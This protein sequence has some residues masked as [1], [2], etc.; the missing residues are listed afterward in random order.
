MKLLEWMCMKMDHKIHIYFYLETFWNHLVVFILKAFRFSRYVTMERKYEK[1]DYDNSLLWNYIYCFTSVLTEMCS[2]NASWG[3][4]IITQTSQCVL[5]PTMTSIR[6]LGNMF[7]DHC[8]IW[9][10]LMTK[11]HY[12]THGYLLFQIPLHDLCSKPHSWDCLSPNFII[13][14]HSWIFTIRFVSKV[15]ATCEA[16]FQNI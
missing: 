2:R 16:S 11:Y 14:S 8:Y 1:L 4:S 6:S 7:G 12:V 3:P 10:L 15:F 9:G 13:E 5:R